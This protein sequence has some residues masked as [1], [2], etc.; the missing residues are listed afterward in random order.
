M[1]YLS[2]KIINVDNI[3]VYN[4]ETVNDIHNY[5]IKAGNNNIIVKNCYILDVPT[6]YKTQFELN[7]TQSLQDIAGIT[8]SEENLLLHDTS[9]LEDTHLVNEIHVEANLGE[10]CKIINLL[11][12]SMFEKYNGNIKLK[13]YPNAKRYCHLD[14]ATA[15]GKSEAGISM[16]HKEFYTDPLTGEKQIMYIFDFLIWVSAKVRIDLQ[17]IETFIYDLIKERNIIIDTISCDQFQSDLI[18]Q[19]FELSGLFRKVLRLSVDININP[20]EY[21]ASQVELGRIKT[22]KCDYLKRQLCALKIENGKIQR[23]TERKDLCDACV[24]A[25][26]LARMNHNDITKYEYTTT[27]IKRFFNN[28]NELFNNDIIIEEI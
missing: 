1:K 16:C 21:F 18:R 17:S 5:A 7:L 20:Y 28:Y 12:D 6:T 23:T 27:E 22:G 19:S 2:K 13:R 24:G 3:P 25:V 9:K 8:T 14:L 15:G 26:E 4:L 11:P 10:G